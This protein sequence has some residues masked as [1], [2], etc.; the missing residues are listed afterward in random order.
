MLTYI[1][2]QSI[3][4]KRW[5]HTPDLITRC[6][7]ILAWSFLIQFQVFEEISFSLFTNATQWPILNILSWLPIPLASKKNP[8]N[9]VGLMVRRAA[10]R[11]VDV[12]SSKR[13]LNH[14]I[15]WSLSWLTQL[16]F[17]VVIIWRYCHNDFISISDFAV[18]AV[19]RE[20]SLLSNHSFQSRA[21]FFFFF[22]V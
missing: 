13:D 17:G 14:C 8:L 4:G 20:H 22:F 15:L 9:T 18:S 12:V 10:D 2:K 5:K 16:L 11:K 1:S 6:S 7:A 19:D 3:D 21:C